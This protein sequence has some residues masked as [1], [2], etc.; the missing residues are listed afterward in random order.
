M[1][2]TIRIE[3]IRKA[4]RVLMEANSLALDDIEWTQGGKPVTFPE[5]ALSIVK[6]RGLNNTDL[7]DMDIASLT[8]PCSL[9][10]QQ[11]MNI[12]SADRKEL[13][14]GHH[15]FEELYSYRMA[16]NALLFNCWARQDIYGVHKSWKHSDG[17]PCFG[18]GWFVVVATTPHGQVSNHYKA[19][20]WDLFS[21]VPERELSSEYDGHTPKQALERLLLTTSD[22]S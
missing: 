11:I 19:K 20:F 14:D 5:D 2:K 17:E 21:A 8:A 22:I 12:P 9:I 16:Y 13:S 1:K 10:Q 4:R 15:T 6:Y 18:G 3:S 7:L